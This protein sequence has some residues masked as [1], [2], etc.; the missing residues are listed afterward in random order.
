M[1]FVSK[2]KRD[3]ADELH[4][5]ARKTFKRRRTIIKGFADLWQADLAEMQSYY[6]QNNGYRYILV[7]IDCFSKYMWTQP[8]KNKTSSDVLKA[9]KD[10]IQVAGYTP[11]NLQTDQG[12]EFYNKYFSKLAN[13]YKINHYST[14][15]TKKAAIVERVIRTLKGWIYKEF[16]IRG[17]YKWIDKLSEITSKYNNKVHRTTKMKP[18][19]VTPET[20]LTVYNHSKI[21]LKAK[22][23]VNDIVRISK[24][25]HLF[26]KG[27]TPNFTTE[28]FKIVKVNITNPVTYMLEDMTGKPIRGCFYE[29]ELQKTKHPDV[30][31][32]EKVIKKKPTKY[33]VKWLGFPSN[34]NS[35]I[36]KNQ[37]V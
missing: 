15:S 24:Y 9:M 31:L 7:V 13:D 25:K 5:Q 14:F 36:E 26:A 11:N 23:K 8:I 16:S 29:M 6:R 2:T 28:L 17:K 27:Y 19:D 12:T 33:Y 22:Y 18:V 10:I 3:I 35:W 30:Y 1:V 37:I 4:K 21:A 20:Q 32:V 34:A